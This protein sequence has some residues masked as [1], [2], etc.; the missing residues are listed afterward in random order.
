[1]NTLGWNSLYKELSGVIGIEATLKLY[2]EYR[3]MQLN[4]PA[5]LISRKHLLICL[6]NEY[7]G[8]NKRELARKYGYSQRTIERMIR[9]FQREN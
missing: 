7:T 9:E 4:L 8:E 2:E 6:K 1:V 5:R 3:G